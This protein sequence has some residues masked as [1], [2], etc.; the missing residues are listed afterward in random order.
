MAQ[1]I[2]LTPSSAQT[3]PLPP[4]LLRRPTPRVV[5]PA[6]EQYLEKQARSI[7]MNGGS[8]LDVE[9]FAA[10]H[11]DK[12]RVQ[13]FSDVRQNI[14]ETGG[15]GATEDNVF[16]GMSL[17]ALQGATFGF[18]DEAMGSLVGLLTGEGASGGI[19]EYRNRLRRFS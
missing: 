19:E 8:L 1:T 10:M 6:E 12:P 3:A 9:N 13:R 17:K 18:G 14:T 7:L 4:P 15:E 11:K 16:S 5:S 2:P